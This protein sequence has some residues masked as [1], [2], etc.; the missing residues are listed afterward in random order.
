MKTKLSLTFAVQLFVA[1][2]AQ[3]QFDYTTNN[4]TITIMGYTGTNPVVVIPDTITGLPV[5]AIGDSAFGYESLTSVTIP[6]SVTN[7]GRDAFYDCERLT[8]VT[9]PS[10]VTSIGTAAFRFCTNLT[11]ITV[12]TN[13]RAYSSLS[14][15][16]FNQSQ[17]VLIEYPGGKAGFYSI[18][19]G[20]TNIED[21]ALY[22]CISLTSVTIPN[23]VASI[24]Y[25]AFI[26]CTGLTNATLG[27]GLVS[28]GY[29]AFYNCTNL[30]SLT[31]P[32]SITSIGGNAFSGS[33]YGVDS[34]L[35][36]ALTSVTIPN[37]VTNIGGD[38]FAGCPFLTN[39][40]I[41]SGITMIGDGVFT[42]CAALTS[43]TIPGSVTSIGQYA[44]SSC[45]NLTRITIPNGV[46]NIGDG[47]FSLCTRLDVTIPDSVTS[48]GDG[49]FDF[50]GLTSVTIPNGVNSVGRIF[51]Y[52]ASLT[53]I[54]ISSSVTNIGTQA[55]SHCT[56]LTSV[57]IP[58]G[59]TSLGSQAFEYC[60]LTSVTIP[61]SVTI[62]GLS[63]F[64]ACTRLTAINVETNNPAY[65]SVGGVLFDHS[66]TRLLAYPGAKAGSYLIPD[67]VTSID[68]GAFYGCPGL[69][70]INVTT[71][72]PDY[73]SVDGVLFFVGFGP[74]Q[75]VLIAYPGGRSGSYSIPNT[76]TDIG[77]GAFYGCAGLTSVTIPES[78][79]TIVGNVFT[80]CA[81]L[82]AINVAANNPAYSSLGGVLFNHSQTALIA[83]PGGKAGPYSIPNGVTF[84]NDQAFYY[85]TNL[86][87]VYFSG[88][89]PDLG[90]DVFYPDDNATAYYL[91]G[92]TGWGTTL[93]DIPTALWTLPSP[94]ILTNSPTFG[95]RTNQFGFT[96]SWANNA[97]V[98]VEA[99]SDLNNPT[100]SSV[101]TNALN[102]GVVN[103]T[104]P[105]WR[106][107]PSRF[108]RVRSQ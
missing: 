75:T 67:S 14:G 56:S 32:N 69:T 58:N 34:F 104:D 50:S 107:Y 37:S 52:C 98:V 18:P 102:N 5:T 97:S 95:V 2:T 20:I 38:A 71:N 84:I 41:G 93:G 43:V 45:S 28:I 68:E 24:G 19:D 10:S 27:T 63:A 61:D 59:V 23:S 11:A 53:N 72:N 94:L 77:F 108:Y 81:S 29:A 48:I 1:P 6:N 30:T 66:L 88:N 70:A 91:P 89:A 51:F 103:F 90:E 42:G 47:A 106:N 85:C 83:Y 15:V 12:E 33:G 92:T 60:G 46:T 78:V 87:G 13:N 54:T 7:I 25:G 26:S 62:I 39:V 49:A 64:Q 79:T 86:T 3:A 82:T 40:T 21:F 8:S 57:T 31:I 36:C 17:T 80:G 101:Q 65:T 9:I 96:V 16:L 74:G 55:F 105:N 4:G 35:A 73:S 44:F 99:T 22:G 100:W 76:V